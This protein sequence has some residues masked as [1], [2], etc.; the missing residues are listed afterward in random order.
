LHLDE[1]NNGQKVPSLYEKTETEKRILIVIPALV[2]LIWRL[3]EKNGGGI[4]G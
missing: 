2:T 1:P 4:A 3:L